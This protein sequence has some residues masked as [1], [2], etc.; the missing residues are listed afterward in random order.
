MSMSKIVFLLKNQ[1][2]KNQLKGISK[3]F[4]SNLEV[5]FL[6]SVNE[7][8]DIVN[9][10]KVE[11]VI[12]DYDEIKVT[13]AYLKSFKKREINSI[14]ISDKIKETISKTKSSGSFYVARDNGDSFI[15]TIPIMVNTLLEC[16]N[17]FMKYEL[18]Y[19]ALE[20]AND[21]IYIANDNDK[22][23][24]ANKEFQRMFGYS[25]KD[26]V[27][28][29]SSVLWKESFTNFKSSRRSKYVELTARK[30]SGK[31]FVATVLSSYFADELYK[32]TYS[33]VVVQD[34]TESKKYTDELNKLSAAVE[35][36]ADIVVIT[37]KDGIIEYVNPGFEKLTGYLKSEVIGKT[38]RILKSGKMSDEFYDA[39]KSKIHLGS[40]FRAIFLNKKKDGAIYYHEQTITPIKDENNSVVRFIS[41]GR[42]ITENMKMEKALQEANEK[43]I[44]WVDELEQRGSE[45]F[46]LSEMANLLQTCL[47]PQ[48]AYTVII[49]S[50]QKLFPNDQGALCV[51][52]ENR[53]RNEVN[54]VGVWGGFRGNKM[55]FALHDC[56]ALRRGKIHFVEN[57]R[58]GL[59]CGHVDSSLDGNYMCV[60]IQS[61]EE[62]IGLL[63]LFN[64]VSDQQPGEVRKFL[65]EAK[66]RLAMTVAEHIALALG[67][68][69]L[70]DKLRIQAIR[71]PLTNLF[72][73]RY[74]E[75]TLD[76]EIHK[77]ARDKSSIGIIMLDLDHF[78]NFNDTFGHSAGDQVLR[79]L[80]EFLKKSIRAGDIV[81]RYGGEEFVLIMPG[82]ILLETTK[83]ANQICEK[84]R[85][86]K[87]EI[88]SNIYKTIT[89]SLGVAAFPDH[90]N[91][92]D[93]LLKTVDDALYQAKTQGRNRVIVYSK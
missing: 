75:E 65:Q 68:I 40:V 30:K 9:K 78:K 7:L 19:H 84:V 71:D 47:S 28:E 1:K 20:N 27:G 66:Q 12:I 4:Q 35:Q 64:K 15:N 93:R 86:M 51:V 52:H 82:A 92:V 56:W 77:A 62:P 37:D 58:T 57:I 13:S 5:L 74:M 34:V 89:L 87:I 26:I 70:R 46:A 10:E 36:T 25:E 49:E 61:H 44:V 22:I 80:G 3:I 29:D 60:P 53:E 72:N 69:K 45:I 85:D 42:D 32:K 41:T 63:Y 11:I 73:R 76:R 88:S 31:E 91:S 33:V 79:K 14:I 39:L 48:E 38:P 54:T 67:N 16:K 24:F 50:L 83:R 81:C 8:K 18:F 21:G 17:T 43:L 90:G 2:T 55:I 23:I 59:L 6:G